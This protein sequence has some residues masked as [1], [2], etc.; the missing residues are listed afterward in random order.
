GGHER[1][2]GDETVDELQEAGTDL[3]QGVDE[4]LAHGRQTYCRFDS[5]A[6]S[7]IS[8]AARALDTGQPF[9]A[10][11]A[12]SAN[13]AWSIPGTSACVRRSILLIE[14]PASP[15]SRCTAAVV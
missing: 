5:V 7:V 13:A 12:C 3:D 15:F 10:A 1:R 8:T 6:S 9:L 14:N 4:L 11:S 2:P